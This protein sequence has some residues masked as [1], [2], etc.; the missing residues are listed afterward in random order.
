M[1]SVPTYALYG[2]HEQPLI[3]E[4]LHLESIAERSRLYDWEIRPHR[5]DLFVQVLCVSAGE[6]QAVFDDRRLPFRAPAAIL[7]P[8]LVVHG[9]R[10]SRDVQGTILTVAQQQ[11]DALLA[12]AP[13]L[14][15]R[16]AH[17]ACLQFPREADRPWFDPIQQQFALLAQELAG[18]APWRLPALAAC[19]TQLL[20]RLGRAAE[21]MAGQAA[22]GS[23]RGLQHARRFRA[24]LERHY[25][26]ER[27]IPWYA[28]QLGLTPTQLNRICRGVLGTSALGALHA[29]LSLQARRDLAYTSLSVKEIAL[30]LGFADAAYFTRFFTRATGVAP[31]AFREA[32]RR[33]LATA[34]PPRPAGAP[35]PTPDAERLDIAPGRTRGLETGRSDADRPEARPPEV[36]FSEAHRSEAVRSEALRLEAVRLEA[37]RSEAG[38]PHAGEPARAD[39]D[40]P[41]RHR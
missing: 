21:H 4:N 14:A 31:T 24:L 37:D 40:P 22:A 19:L 41:I 32:A 33:Q 17:S 7:V 38:R 6:G 35:A 30:A 1:K 29:R 20:V 13:S 12:S 18:D 15:E 3:P 28:G 16:L 34:V 5:H 39:L 2:E 25:R 27:R 10:F 11:V 23:G 26:R 8:A 9:F 36:R